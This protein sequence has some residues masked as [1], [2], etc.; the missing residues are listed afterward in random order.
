MPSEQTDKLININNKTKSKDIK[1]IIDQ[2]IPSCGEIGCRTC[3]KRHVELAEALKDYYHQQLEAKVIETAK[4]YGGCTNC[5]GKGYATVND[6]WHGHDT[7]TD[8]GSPGGH[9]SGGNPNAMKYCKCDRGKQ[10]KAL[11]ARELKAKGPRFLCDHDENLYRATID[12]V[13]G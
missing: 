4:A 6:R 2:V 9:V 1:K 10:L 5:Y 12:E 8:I 13:L 7:D 11:I 3:E